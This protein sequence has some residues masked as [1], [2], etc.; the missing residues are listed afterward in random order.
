MRMRLGSWLMIAAVAAGGVV[1]GR[2]SRGAQPGAGE[3]AVRLAQ[4]MAVSASRRDAA[5]NGKLIPQTD[6]VVYVSNGN[7]VT[8][9]QYVETLGKY[10]ASLKTLDFRW[11]R[12]EASPLGDSAAVFTGW[13]TAKTVDQMGKTEAGRALFTMVFARDATG[14]K[15]VIAQ[16]W[17][18]QVPKVSAAWAVAPSRSVPPDSPIAVHFSPAVNASGSA[19][20]LECPA[21]SPIPATAT[22]ETPGDGTSFLVRADHGLPAGANCLLTV[23]APQI[24]DDHFGQPMA[25][26]YRFTF[27]VAAAS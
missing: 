8:G 11:D 4:E 15:R 1:I 17:Q 14:W 22:P 19:F 6:R 21:G 27:T 10:Y 25:E 13:A 7:P 5:S 9:R 18:A 20:K 24:S 23:A 16:K 26:D 12:W 2:V 3:M